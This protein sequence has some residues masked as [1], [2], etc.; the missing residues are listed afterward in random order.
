MKTLIKS[1]VVAGALALAATTQADA[2]SGRAA[3]VDAGYGDY[4]YA[5]R[6]GGQSYYNS[7]LDDQAYGYRTPV[8]RPMDS[9]SM[10]KR[11]LEG[12]E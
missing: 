5:P 8:N 9:G 10:N 4:A 12:W 7:Y 2:R 6:G 11:H 3:A 1:V